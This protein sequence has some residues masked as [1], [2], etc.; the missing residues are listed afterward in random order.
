M[1]RSRSS[2]PVRTQ[3]RCYAAGL[4]GG[5]SFGR[6]RRSVVSNAGILEKLACESAELSVGVIAAG[7][8][9]S[10]ALTRTTG[11]SAPIDTIR[12]GFVTAVIPLICVT[13]GYL[14][15][16]TPMGWAVRTRRGSAT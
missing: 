6:P 8:V 15:C 11:T 16:S 4:L 10:R 3:I 1:E 13:P 12:E 7:N 9:R 14:S 5:D 2:P